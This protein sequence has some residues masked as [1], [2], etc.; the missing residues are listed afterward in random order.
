MTPEIQARG[1]LIRLASFGLV[2]FVSSQPG[3]REAWEL[4]NL[5][6]SKGGKASYREAQP[7]LVLTIRPN[8]STCYQSFAVTF[9][10][11][12]SSSID[13]GVTKIGDSKISRYAIVTA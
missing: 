3:Q 8:T 11:A 7:P 2:S 12:A 9:G 10:T 4:E 1:R 13:A 6:N 5:L